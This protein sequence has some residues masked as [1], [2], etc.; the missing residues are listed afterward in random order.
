[1]KVMLVDDERLI[2]ISLKSMLEES[3]FPIQMIEEAANG[4]EMVEKIKNWQP[5]IAFV[6]IQMPGLNGLDAI[7]IV[8]A[9]S[10]CTQWIIL[11]GYS[12]FSY[13]REALDIGVSGYLLK[14]VSPDELHIGLEKAKNSR[15]GYLSKLN[16]EF[17]NE[18]SSYFHG[19]CTIKEITKKFVNSNY[20]LTIFYID[21][22]LEESE[23]TMR[24][25]NFCTQL[26]TIIN[27]CQSNN[28]RFA[29][30]ALS[31]KELALITIWGL[32]E[33]Q[34][35]GEAI[36]KC[37]QKIEEILPFNCSDDFSLTMIS[38]S[39][40][41]IGGTLNI[42]KEIRDV[43]SLRTVYGINQK[44]TLGQLKQI[45]QQKGV[46]QL[47]SMLIKLSEFYSNRVSLNFLKILNDLEKK[48][49]GIEFN[50]VKT[51]LRQFL[52]V[53]I[54][55]QLDLNGT[56][57]D[58]IGVLRNCSENLLN[59]PIQEEDR[60]Q[61]L[62]EQVIMY[63]DEHY[64]DDIGIGQIAQEL[65][66]TP[67]YL[68][69]LFHK[70]MGTTFTKYLTTSRILKAKEL[71]ADPRNNVQRVAELVGYYSTRHFTKL[72]TELVGCYPSE[73][74]KNLKNNRKRLQGS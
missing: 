61:H 31:N 55:C 47:S 67:N 17:E 40:S 21:S 9:L 42:V 2:R 69:T 64:M 1:M 68:S 43:S 25:T 54:P 73:Y 45:K 53:A 48:F 24:V 63:I 56:A 12:E 10:P 19:L 37:L 30:F 51:S 36:K 3:R 57:S 23:R 8:Q 32:S 39:S 15:Q 65:H 46:Y 35:G 66:V 14:P 11:T 49:T 22:H 29:L 50:K 16:R 20:Q 74:Q 28:T 62:V 33:I 52:S 70:K 5:D 27:D 7:K 4:T 60:S 58:W 41:K 59:D 6:D 34:D 72:F 44:W 18:M 26:Q 38:S 71:L 13:A